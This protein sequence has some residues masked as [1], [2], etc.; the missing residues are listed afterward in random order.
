MRSTPVP[1]TSRVKDDFSR[2]FLKNHGG[3]VDTDDRDAS[4]FNRIR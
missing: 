3:R 4:V 2:V 1:E